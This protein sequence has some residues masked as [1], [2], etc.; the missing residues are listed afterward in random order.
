MM[1][2]ELNNLP[3]QAGLTAGALA[4][5]AEL[6][7]ALYDL[8]WMVL[9]VFV[10]ICLDFG[11]GVADS[12]GRRRE[13][14]HLSR[15]GRRT[16]CKFIEYLAY[17]VTGMVLGYAVFEPLGVCTHVQ[18]AAAGL[19]LAILWEADSIAEHVCALHGISERF[20]IKRIIINFLVKKFN[21][22]DKKR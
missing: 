14:F 22:S 11:Y 7:A 1:Q 12:V 6:T 17:L 19:L 10:L 5:G 8:R 4:F 16:T 2:S 3:S 9:A 15:A 20:S 18:S 21:D 13:E